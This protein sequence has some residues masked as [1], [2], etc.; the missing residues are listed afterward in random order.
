M[1]RS[2]APWRAP[3]A[4]QVAGLVV[5]AT[6]ASSAAAYAAHLFKA[7]ADDD[8]GRAATRWCQVTRMLFEDS[9]PLQAPLGRALDLVDPAWLTPSIERGDGRWVRAY[10]ETKSHMSRFRSCWESDSR[11][12]S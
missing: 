8:I 6:V 12:P 1:D 11:A 2:S 5:A 10:L 3:G 4:I 7:R 9:S